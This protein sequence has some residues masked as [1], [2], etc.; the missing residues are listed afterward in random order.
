M[1]AASRSPPSGAPR[2]AATWRASSSA[3]AND[4]SRV[5]EHDGD[6]RPRAAARCTSR[7]PMVPSVITRVGRSASTAS[8]LMVCPPVVTSGR[9][10]AAG[11]RRRHVASD[12][13]VAEAETLD[14]G[15]DRSGEVESEH[16]R[17]VVDDDLAVTG[18]IVRHDGGRQHLFRPRV[19]GRDLGIRAAPPCSDPRRRAGRRRRRQ[20]GERR[21]A[22][23]GGGSASPTA[24]PS[25][26]VRSSATA[27]SAAIARRSRTR[28]P[29]TG[30]EEDRAH[31]R[32]DDR[33]RAEDRRPR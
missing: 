7:G 30:G 18:P 13:R 12:E 15:G 4:G 8:A 32:R 33:E 10:S 9:S 6:A 14:G 3:P 5:D 17:R 16:P 21:L 24:A 29:T 25:R 19:E 23:D 11:E 22:R 20:L 31:D 2:A 27:A 1:S 26:P 28:P